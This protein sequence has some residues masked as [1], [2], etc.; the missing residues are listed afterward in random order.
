MNDILQTNITSYVTLFRDL[1]VIKEHSVFFNRYS[2]P[3]YSIFSL[4]F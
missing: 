3:L 2:H 4:F 1:T